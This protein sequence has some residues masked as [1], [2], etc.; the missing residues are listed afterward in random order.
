[1]IGY[2]L[3]KATWVGRATTFCV[4]LV[5]ILILV[6]GVGTTAL[7]AVPGDP[8]RLGRLNAVDRMTA[9]VGS[10][11]GPLLKVDNNGG[12]P[13][14]ALE[15]NSGRPPLT[16]SAGASKAINLDADRLDGKDASAFLPV[17]GKAA[18]AATADTAGDAG[19]LDG[20]DS[21]DFLPVDGMA[22]DAEK[23]D[24]LDAYQFMRS[25]TYYHRNTSTFASDGTQ[26]VTANCP[27]SPREFTAISGGASVVAPDAAGEAG[28]AEIPVALKVDRPEGRS[29]WV[30][31]AS[32]TSPYGG[33][34]A[35]KVQVVCVLQTQSYAYPA[36]EDGR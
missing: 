5:V 10:V 22:R 13:A 18:N 11:S 3:R 2:V 31:V 30:A 36:D 15:S 25:A 6:L 26:T 34:W 33:E 20:K 24:G 4:G 17:D 19:A 14:L 35:L 7:A 29:S 28:L 21:S 8:F 27:R 23:V 32:E 12:G 1:M 16:V 9:L